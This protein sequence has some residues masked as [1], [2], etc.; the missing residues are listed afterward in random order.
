MSLPQPTIFQAPQATAR[1]ARA[2]FPKGNLYMQ[3][4]DTLGSVY[5]EDQFADVFS[6]TGQPAESPVRLT[7]VSIL[8]YVEGL[9]D[10]QAADAV[11]TRI[12]WKYLLGL[13]LEDVGFHHSVLS[14][15]RTRLLTGNVEQRLLD[16]LLEVCREQGWLKERGQQRT[17]STHVLGA[18]RALN[19]LEC[20]GETLRHTLNVLA[21]TV[22]EWLRVHSDPEWTDR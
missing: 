12:D 18:V 4:H 16:R 15:F 3:L 10:R 2:I 5:E 14:E 19:R 22:P 8:Q 9:T 1:V 20:V 11:R 21:V 7:L 17:D 13:E 6:H